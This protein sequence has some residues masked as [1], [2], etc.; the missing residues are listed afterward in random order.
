MGAPPQTPPPPPPPPA[1]PP[2]LSAAPRDNIQD[3]AQLRQDAL[4][5]AQGG[6]AS[7]QIA[8]ALNLHE[9]LVDQWVDEEAVRGAQAHILGRQ[10]NLPVTVGTPR[11]AQPVRRK[12]TRRGEIPSA[13]RWKVVELRLQGIAM[14]R[15]AA[16]LEIDMTSV[17]EILE[18]TFLDHTLLNKP[19]VLNQLRQMELERLDLLQSAFWSAA[20][21]GDKDSFE[22]VMKVIKRRAE[23]LGLDAPK[24]TASKAVTTTA[25][26]KRISVQELERTLANMDD[27]KFDRLIR[28]ADAQARL[29]ETGGKVPEPLAAQGVGGSD[30]APAPTKGAYSRKRTLR[31]RLDLRDAV[32]DLLPEER[33]GRLPADLDWDDDDPDVELTVRETVQVSGTGDPPRGQHG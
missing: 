20:C 8:D 2:P 19:G 25:R 23:M 33:N 22:C 14:R 30:L 16:L 29:L 31:S 3:L 12:T 28:A 15:I 9:E 11:R 10:H 32:P 6:L 13:V 4:V 5:L 1:A 27:A 17:K 24:W 7:K 18:E 21:E 26:A